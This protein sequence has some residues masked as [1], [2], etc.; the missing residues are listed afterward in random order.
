MANL[1]IE[2]GNTA[3]KAAW[4]EGIILGKTFRYQGEKAMAFIVSLVEKERPAVLIVASVYVISRKDEKELS[5]YC[6]KLL[7]LDNSNTRTLADYSLPD[8]IT[9][10]RAASIIAARY[11]FKGKG[12]TVFD[13][14]TTLTVDFI[15]NQGKYSGGNISLG[16][17]TRFK[18][19]NRYSKALPLVN[20]P[21][22]IEEEGH[23]IQKSIESGV[24]SGIMFEIEGYASFRPA[25]VIVFTGGDAVYFAKRMKNSIFVICNL[26]LM[27]LALIA[28]EYVQ[29]NLR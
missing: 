9:Y 25:N 26:V 20:T 1:V 24:I 11:L 28:D 8:Y 29:K 23:S 2:I 4:S 27:G 18:A 10:D 22:S 21:D 17:R 12:C 6:G 14:G 5:G 13:F 19:L 7:I 16:C 15:E 3:V